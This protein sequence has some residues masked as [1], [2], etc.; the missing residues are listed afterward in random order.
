MVQTE[1][2]LS[3]VSQRI[4]DQGPREEPGGPTVKEVVVDED[5]DIEVVTISS[6]EEETVEEGNRRA[7]IE[8]WLELPLLP[9]GY[10]FREY[11]YYSSFSS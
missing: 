2:V 5:E 8:V 6:D 11:E 7:Q 10:S 4:E 9:S 1:Q 3:L